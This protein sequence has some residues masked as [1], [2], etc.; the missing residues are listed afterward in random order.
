MADRVATITLNRP[1]RLN[2]FN[3]QVMRDLIAAFDL[4]DGDDGVRCVIVTG[5]GR[6]FCAGADLHS[7]GDTF[8]YAKGPRANALRADGSVDWK[9]ESVRDT[10]GIA[11]LRIYNS[12]KPVIAAI[13]GPA[14]G[15][16]ITLT[17]PMDICLVA[18]GAKI[19]FVFARR[20]I[21]PESASSWFLPRLVG[22]SRAVEWCTTGRVFLPDE[23]MAAGL[24]RSK[25]AANELMP[26]ALTLAQEIAGSAP[27]SV[28]LTR[29]MLWKA[30]SMAEPMEAHQVESRGVFALGRSDDAREGVASFLE[31][32]T[33][34]TATACPPTCQSGIL[35]GKRQN[36]GSAKATAPASLPTPLT[37]GCG[38]AA[39]SKARRSLSVFP[40]FAR[41]HSAGGAD[42]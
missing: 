36:G 4:S 14:V 1:D 42:V 19:G 41:N 13:N 5:A 20:G 32:R 23:G 9:H 8:D 21:V 10:G 34:F 3:T 12:L 37:V 31:K 15:V 2:A 11:S 30:L 17:L 7:G 40:L 25:H 26:M 16:G 22:I 24:F 39:P 38:D 33:P 28:T 6:A 18:E 27:V 35:G 29:K